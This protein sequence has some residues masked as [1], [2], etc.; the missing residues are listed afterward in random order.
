MK[1]VF[2]TR[3][4]Y[5]SQ[6]GG[7]ELHT[8]DI[9]KHFREIGHNVEFLGSCEVL[10]GLAHEND[11]EFKRSWLYKPP[12]SFMSLI[13]FSLM[14]PLLFLLAWIKVSKIRLKKDPVVYMLSFG[15]KLLMTPFCKAY[16]IDCI[17]VE[18]ARIGGWFHKNPWKFWYRFWSKYVKVVTV[19]K[20]MR[21]DLGLK[22]TYVIENAI[23]TN[24]FKRLQDVNVLPKRLRESLGENEI[25]VGYVGRLSSDKGM[26][27]LIKAKR[28]M[29]NIGFVTVGSGPF[30][31]KLNKS[32]ISNYPFLERIQVACFMQ[33]IDVFVLPAT[34]KDPFGLVVLEAMAAGTPVICSDL[35]GIS[36][37]LDDGIDCIVS[38]DDGFVS[39]LR[40]LLDNEKK[41]KDLG[42]HG[43][44][45]VMRKFSHK[46]MLEDFEKLL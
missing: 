39:E 12:V 25:N 17:W 16:G 37:S 18:H 23:D 1:N 42:S 20:M 14:S 31:G 21:R 45:T 27:L 30:L 34:Q 36:E 10:S 6:L 22:K 33:N 28:E 7:E 4:P 19:S 35:C 9:A 2:I 13:L 43:Q 32:G 11:F 40:K 3:F 44:E 15:E 29:P 38:S 26:E 8:L 5:E 41:R 46:R 24:F